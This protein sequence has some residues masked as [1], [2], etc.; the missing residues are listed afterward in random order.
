MTQL[1]PLLL[2]E[3]PREGRCLEIGV[4]TGRIALPLAREGVSLVGID[5]SS[6]MLHRLMINAG[7]S[8]PPIAIGDATR[9]PFGDHL[10]ASAIAS[11]VFHLVP[12][13]KIAV[14]ELFRVL[15]PDGIILAS[16]GG[17]S[18]DGWERKVSRHFFIQAGDPP[19][20]PGIDRIEEL[21]EYMRS[22]GAAIRALPIPSREGASSI[23]ALLADLE[24]GYWSGCWSLD[25]PARRR[26][27]AV[28]REWARD[29]I[30][31]LDEMR[32]SAESTVWHAYELG[33]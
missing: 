1:I 8:H 27:A 13:W 33:K 21:D 2:A 9:L 29:E 7:S 25:E 6:E 22:R 3:I 24:A 20:P 14:D 5:I 18:V 11:H 15:R 17:R 10:F 31:D 12:D 16:R 4:G 32:P 30:G 28:T 19:W 26:A 23:S